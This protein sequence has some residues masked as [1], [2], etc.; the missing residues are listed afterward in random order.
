MSLKVAH[1]S[2]VGE[3]LG[4][5]VTET[6]T[7]PATRGRRSALAFLRELIFVVV[8][9]LIVSSLLR[10]FVGQM[11]II[12]SASMQNTLLEGGLLHDLVTGGVRRLGPG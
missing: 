6:T 10:A 8:G 4:R 7:R 9:A 1:P 12:P 5:V 11:F 3:I 2:A